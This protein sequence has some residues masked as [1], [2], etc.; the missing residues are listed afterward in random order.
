MTL[1]TACNT[2]A[3]EG[4]TTSAPIEENTLDNEGN[5][6]QLSTEVEQSNTPLVVDGEP[7][8]PSPASQLSK[9]KIVS[10]S[11]ELDYSIEHLSNF[12]LIAEEPGKDMLVYNDNDAI[13]IPTAEVAFT[14][15]LAETE[16]LTVVIAPEGKYKEYDLSTYMEQHSDIISE[17]SYLVEYESD[18]VVTVIY[19]ANEKIVRLTI[20]DDYITDLAS[21]F[22]E[23]GFTIH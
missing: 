9:E 14:D 11:E 5:E 4:V 2:D 18:R 17:A 19:E 21:T 16:D 23:M 3:Q 12:T 6:Q 8:N 22:L 1:L 7:E 20:Y 15:I 10:A 13:S